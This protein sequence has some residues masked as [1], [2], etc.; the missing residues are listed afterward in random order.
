V[1]TDKRERQKLGRQARIE[2]EMAAAKRQRTF[3]TARNLGIVAVV[4]L[5]GAFAYS[6]ITGGGSSG[7]DEKKDKNANCVAS[8]SAPNAYCN[9]KLAKEVLERKPPEVTAAPAST[10]KDALETKTL[11]H[12]EGTGAKAGDMITAHYVLKTPDPKVGQSSWESGQPLSPFA[13]GKGNVIPGWDKGLVGAKIGERRQLIIGSENGYGAAGK[14]DIKPNTPLTFVI[15]IV[16]IK[17][18]Q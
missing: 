1:G 3:R 17:T 10:P 2:Q 13:L 15:D 7:A 14:A 5:G 18:G 6:A 11:I 12:G 8:T 9:P 4:V 16:D